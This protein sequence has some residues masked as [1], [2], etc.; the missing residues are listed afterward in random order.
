MLFKRPKCKPVISEKLIIDNVEIE[1]VD[2]TKFL[3]VMIDECLDFKKQIKYT[4][5]KVARGVGILRKCKPFVD[6][7]I[8][9]TLYNT[10]VYP[11]CTY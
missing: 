6:N 9:Q 8:M 2:H 7:N 11:Y 5:G 3:G 1:K 10:F 4:K